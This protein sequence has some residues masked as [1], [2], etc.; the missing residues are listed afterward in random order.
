MAEARGRIRWCRLG[1]ADA[2]R[3][4]G[5]DAH[6][7]LSHKEA[8]RR[9]RA[10]GSN[11]FAEPPRRTAWLLRGL[12]ADVV[13][14]V[15]L[16]CGVFSL[17][18]GEWIDGLPFFLLLVAWGVLFVGRLLRAIGRLRNG[19][20]FFDVPSVTVMRDGE[21][22]LI[23]ATRVVRGDVIVLH[24]GDILPCDCRLLSDEELTVRLTWRES[25]KPT[26]HLYRKRAD[27]VYAYGDAVS[28]P[29]AENMVYGGSVIVSGSAVALAVELGETSF[30]GRLGE[31]RTADRRTDGATPEG[32]LPYCRLLSFVSLLLLFLCGITA[33]FVAPK[34]YTALRVFL[35][36]CVMSASA[37]VGVTELYFTAICLRGRRAAAAPRAGRDR[38]LIRSDAT[39]R[40][41]SRLDELYIVGTAALSDGKRHFRSGATAHGVSVDGAALRPLAEAFVLLAKAREALPA[42]QCERFTDPEDMTYLGELFRASGLDLHALDIRL[43]QVTLL[44]A[45][46]E[47]LLQIVTNTETYR[48]HLSCG[49]AAVATCSEVLTAQGC[50]PMTPQRLECFLRYAADEEACGRH[51]RAAVREF[52]GR[53]T[54]IGLLSLGEAVL[55]DLAARLARLRDMGVRVAVCLDRDAETAERYVRSVCPEATVSTAERLFADTNGGA[56]RFVAGIG[57]AELAAGLRTRT[58]AGRTVGLLCNRTD[59]RALLGSASIRFVADDCFALAAE[60]GGD[61]PEQIRFGALCTEDV[62]MQSVRDGADVILARANASGGGLAAI[63]PTL[64]RAR[65]TAR[66]LAAFARSA[67]LLRVVRMLF[68]TLCT[69]SGLGPPTAAETFLLSFG[70]DLVALWAALFGGLRRE[71][72]ETPIAAERMGLPQSFR[73]RALWLSVL[74]PPAAVWLL[75]LLLRV[76][77]LLSAEA[78]QSIAPIG[79]AVFEAVLLIFAESEDV[80]MRTASGYAVIAAVLV[81]PL[82]PSILCSILIPS[83]GEVTGL[84]AWSPASVILTIVCFLGALCGTVP[85]LRRERK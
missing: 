37:S 50:L 30:L 12:A 35:S 44:A 56:P 6:R 3:T 19:L 32:L 36:V 4:L 59:S 40:A 60:S 85:L 48:L 63:E 76:T 38:V 5:S 10:D 29:N 57:H 81:A 61:A 51:I 82:L 15:T 54:L 52:G 23:P 34:D 66:R 28:H 70:C 20:S 65:G 41:L 68:F 27:R 39:M 72:G 8:Y 49:A 16:L 13:P 78:A 75:S 80:R 64:R 31:R 33:L 9:L 7:G 55:P 11:R 2:V 79:L 84:G 24:A 73:D 74:I 58:R 26:P 43:R 25:E 1:A 47:E 69:L 45:G 21:A 22:F 18:S 77:G 83:F 17:C 62:C 14:I 53:M 71:G 46:E 67:A 42:A